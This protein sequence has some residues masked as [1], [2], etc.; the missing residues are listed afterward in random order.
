[1]PANIA[2]PEAA[3]RVPDGLPAPHARAVY[4]LANLLLIELRA[5]LGFTLTETLLRDPDL[6]RDRR[7]E[8]ERAAAI[9]GR[10][11]TDE[12]IHVRSLRLVLGELRRAR[13][14]TK[15]GGTLPGEAVVD[16]LWEGIVR[17]ATVEQPPLAAAQ[18]RR[19]LH[20]RVMRHPEGARV[21]RAFEAL[22]EA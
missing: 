11:R 8:A 20:E 7:A 22:D 12:E 5:E 18:Q 3:L 6:F 1:V 9:V 19:V 17:W 21:W 16:P 15:A 2:R 10:I 14:R 4:F 13:F